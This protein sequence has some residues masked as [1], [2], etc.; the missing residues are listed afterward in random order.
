MNHLETTWRSRVGKMYAVLPIY[1]GCWLFLLGS[2]MI[3][4]FF[5]GTNM[6]EV[7]EC[8]SQMS[9]SYVIVPCFANSVAYGEAYNVFHL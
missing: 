4:D 6:S 8:S 1:Q 9:R 2:Q 7:L 5:P 3:F